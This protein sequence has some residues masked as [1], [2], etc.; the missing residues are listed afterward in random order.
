MGCSSY[1]E[2]IIV[3]S[4]HL[5]SPSSL[6]PSLPPSLFSFLPSNKV[7]ETICNYCGGRG[8]S[9]PVREKNCICDIIKEVRPL[10][11]Q[12]M[13]PMVSLTEGQVSLVA[14]VGKI[15]FKH[16]LRLSD[17]C[18]RELIQWL[19]LLGNNVLLWPRP[20]YSATVL[21]SLRRLLWLRSTS[22]S[23]LGLSLFSL[24]LPF[25]GPLIHRPMWLSILLSFL[26]ST[27]HHSI[28]LNCPHFVLLLRLFVECH[29]LCIFL[30][31]WFFLIHNFYS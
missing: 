1:Q 5:L 8:T 19:P 4:L 6:P 14:N 23:L 13:Y 11:G 20:S 9:K 18:P 22:R 16:P 3:C 7:R 29:F 10:A 30:P 25:W 26:S 21:A 24:F 2:W 31:L 28:N 17:K 27:S 12:L 15:I